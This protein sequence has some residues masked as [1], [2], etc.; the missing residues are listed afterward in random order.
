MICG[1]ITENLTTALSPTS[2]PKSYNS[3]QGTGIIIHAGYAPYSEN[4][5]LIGRVI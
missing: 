3:N 5:C 2:M 1:Q 4:V